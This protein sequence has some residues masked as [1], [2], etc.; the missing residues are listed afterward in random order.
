[1]LK[2]LALA[3]VGSIAILDD[4]EVENANE[5][6]GQFLIRPKDIGKKVGFLFILLCS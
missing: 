4:S 2:N 6:E 5:L 3:G 1:M